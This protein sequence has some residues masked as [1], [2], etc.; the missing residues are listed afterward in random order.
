MQ[1]QQNTL[2]TFGDLQFFYA[3]AWRCCVT[4]SRETDGFDMQKT[5]SG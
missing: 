1:V 2:G 4:F 5:F 3:A